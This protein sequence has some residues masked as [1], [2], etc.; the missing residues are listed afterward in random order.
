MPR[1]SPF[2]FSPFLNL[3]VCASLSAAN[4]PVVPLNFAYISSESK[5]PR[6]AVENCIHEIVQVGRCRHAKRATSQVLT[7]VTT[8]PAR[9]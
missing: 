5:F 4:I 3:V 8:P 9:P 2:S 1:P 7:D 6:N